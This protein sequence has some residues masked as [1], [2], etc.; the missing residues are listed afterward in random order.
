MRLRVFSPEPR[1]AAPP[2]PRQGG[3]GTLQ[4]D[5]PMWGGM[6]RVVVWTFGVSDALILGRGRH[7]TM[8]FLS[9]QTLNSKP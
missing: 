3:R 9:E 7:P 1:R 5:G 8:M 6:F 4:R 2:P